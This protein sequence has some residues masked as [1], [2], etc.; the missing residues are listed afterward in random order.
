MDFPLLL[1]KP[2]VFFSFK[3]HFLGRVFPCSHTHTLRECFSYKLACSLCFLFGNSHHIYKEKVRVAQSCPT[4]CDPMDYTVPGILQARILE[5]VAFPFCRRSSQPR[6]S[7]IT[8]LIYF[9]LLLECKS[10]E[11]RS[12]F[13]LFHCSVSSTEVSW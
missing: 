3:W 2:C 8:C 9:S 5:W 13:Y 6:G 11:G 12:Q 7:V 10:H 4:L 1:A